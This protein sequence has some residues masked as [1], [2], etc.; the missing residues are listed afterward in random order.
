MSEPMI[1]TIDDV[2]K[3]GICVAGARRWFNQHGIP[4]NQFIKDG[5]DA[6]ELIALGDDMARRVV[7]HKK[8]SEAAGG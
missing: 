8:A 4:F 1:I 2:R 5:I 3:A 7:D 6:D